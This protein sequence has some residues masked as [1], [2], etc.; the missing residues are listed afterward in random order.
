MCLYGLTT[1]IL[2]CSQTF[3][4]RCQSG[5]S[6]LCVRSTQS[7]SSQIPLLLYGV[8]HRSDLDGSKDPA[9][10]RTHGSSSLDSGTTIHTTIRTHSGSRSA[11]PG[12]SKPWPVSWKVIG[13]RLH[14]EQVLVVITDSRRPSFAPFATVTCLT[15]DEAHVVGC[16]SARPRSKPRVQNSLGRAWRSVSLPPHLQSQFALPDRCSLHRTTSSPSSSTVILST[17]TSTSSIPS[18]VTSTST[19]SPNSPSV[20]TTTSTSTSSTSAATPTGYDAFNC[21]ADLPFSCHNTT[22]IDNTC[23]FESP[24]GLILQTQFWDTNPAS[25]PNNSWTI[26]G[27]WPDNCDGKILMGRA[28]WNV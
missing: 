12:R 26:H 17:S 11:L 3:G 2:P 16:A 9:T 10:P 22:A 24:G 20:V 23:C 18:V 21:P 7:P 15:G 28:V 1:W 8:S 25:G 27:L 6:E 14:P 4:K 19:S 5:S 13:I